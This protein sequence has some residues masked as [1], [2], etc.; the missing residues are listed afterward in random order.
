VDRIM[1]LLSGMRASIPPTVALDTNFNRTTTIRASVHDIEITMLLTVALVIMLFFL[2]LRKC[3]GTIIPEHCG[4]S[5]HRGTFGVMS[6]L[7]YSL[8]NLSSDGPGDLHGF[9]VDDA[10]V[11]NRKH[12]TLSGSRGFAARSGDEGFP[13][14]RFTVLSMSTSLI[15]VFIPLC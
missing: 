11:V 12:L 8:D 13:R 9:V 10:I 5:F 7:H 4:A 1:A 6:L 2:F 15:A 14:D 3:L